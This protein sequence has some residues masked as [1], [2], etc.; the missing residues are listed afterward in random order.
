MAHAMPL[1]LYKPPQLQ[2]LRIRRALVCDILECTL[3]ADTNALLRAH[4]LLGPV[5]TGFSNRGR[6]DTPSNLTRSWLPLT[7]SELR[8]MY[9]S[10]YPVL[11]L[12]EYTCRLPTAEYVMY[13]GTSP[14]P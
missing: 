2:T 5:Q 9:V 14:R 11:S 4:L 6:R 13:D 3:L 1:E 7:A 8:G 12:N 10:E